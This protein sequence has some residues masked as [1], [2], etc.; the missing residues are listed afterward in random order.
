MSPT[1]LAT[2]FVLSAAPP[3]ALSP[4]QAMLLAR[5]PADPAAA[6]KVLESVYGTDHRALEEALK[7]LGAT[8][9]L[10]AMRARLEGPSHWI[11]V[12]IRWAARHL[13]LLS[14]LNVDRASRLLQA[15]AFYNRAG[16]LLSSGQA[17]AAASEAVKSVKLTESMVGR[18]H[19]FTLPPL[20]RL[21]VAVASLGDSR[22]AMLLA[23]RLLEDA[24]A[25]FGKEHPDRAT[26][27]ETVGVLH[28][29]L[30]AKARSVSILREALAL[31]EQLH[32]PRH[33][34]L[35]QCLFHLGEALL[36]AGQP[37]EAAAMLERSLPGLSLGEDKTSL[38]LSCQALLLLAKAR[39]QVKGPVAAM[40][41]FREAL[42]LASSRLGPD[43]P[44]V[45]EAQEGLAG[46][47]ARRREGREEAVRLLWQALESRK[48]SQGS[49]HLSYGKTLNQ[50]ASVQEAM[51]RPGQALVLNGQALAITRAHLEATAGA[52]DDAGLMRDLAAIRPALGL[53]LSLPDES[54]DASHSE[55]LWWKGAVFSQQAEGRAALRV[56]SEARSMPAARKLLE[57][58]RRVSEQY[59]LL[60]AQEGPGVPER[61]E[62]LA[63]EKSQLEAG[64]AAM[65][66]SI[67]EVRRKPASNQVAELL[68]DGAVLID[69]VV[70]HGRPTGEP[71][72]TLSPQLSAW[73]LR[74]GAPPL[75]VDL[76]PLAPVIEA[77]GRWR[78]SL[79]VGRDSPALAARLKKLVWAPTEK[80]LDGAKVV[81]VSPDGV[82]GALPWAALPGAKPG[83]YL[84]EDWAVGVVPFPRSLSW[85]LRPVESSRNLLA[86]G[87]VDYDA[88][89]HGTAAARKR[90]FAP[91]AAAQM[92]ADAVIEA[93]KGSARRLVGGTP[94]RPA[95]REALPRHRFAHLATHGLYEAAGDEHHPGLSS[96]L[97]LAGANRPTRADTG[98][99]TALEVAEL[100]LS[101]MELAVLSACET[102]LGDVTLGEGLLGLQR[103]F[104][105]AGC[106]SVAA[107]LWSV[108][109]AATSVLMERFYAHLWKGGIGKVQALRQAQLDILRS[110]EL[111][112]ARW[113]SLASVR[114]ARGLK[115]AMPAV[116]GARRSPPAWWAGWQLS[117]DWR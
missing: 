76:G 109:D 77:L 116:G 63:F 83:T 102:A 88:A 49:R 81:L 2:F 9:R 101:R 11:S 94:T 5:I 17:R 69:Y 66:S 41:D 106:R 34:S 24:E 26:A 95:L 84:I 71:A 70:Y 56:L 43:H 42:K 28:G 112:E 65:S 19:P 3:A 68:P 33:R 67:R 78:E 44:V 46:V 113:K 97:A 79:Q 90:G 21:C 27:L 82:L 4:E 111:V 117:G 93:F 12:E 80:Y 61:L 29:Q 30:G 100:D 87:G 72:G 64:L 60:A 25:V 48:K 104:A 62:A 89:L 107:S 98:T 13:E 99:L 15:L 51:G 35:A 37:R 7:R 10:W 23:N 105:V 36:D 55:A 31:R 85:V 8:S 45:A 58:L 59:A 53:R 52:R 20:S 73:V 115:V 1:I 57:G 32:H 38:L 96:L 47:L 14:S 86:V 22:N 54:D 39:L 103:A 18:H 6:L 91:L 16:S 114:G 110:P 50:L 75:R 108:D 74:R 40:P 92:E